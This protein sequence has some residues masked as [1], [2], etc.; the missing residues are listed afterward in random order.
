ME[1]RKLFFGSIACFASALVISLVTKLYVDSIPYG[2]ADMFVPNFSIFLI[3]LLAGFA[4]FWLI[5]FGAILMTRFITK[6]IKSSGKDN[7]DK[8]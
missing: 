6:S 4:V 7:N 3:Y 2:G 8:R 1:N 5:I